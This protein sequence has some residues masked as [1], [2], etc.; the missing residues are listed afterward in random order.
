MP[1]LRT[2][3]AAVALVLLAGAGCSQ[4]E[5][6]QFARDGTSTTTS[7]APSVTVTP[8][9]SDVPATS[10]PEVTTT[11]IGNPT[12][13]ART[14]TTVGGPGLPPLPPPTQPVITGA[15]TDE[16]A[17]NLRSEPGCEGG[18]AVVRLFWRPVGAAEQQVAV[19]ARP[20]GLDGGNYTTSET[21]PAARG[22]YVLRESQP[23]G[24]YYWRVLTRRGSGWAASET[25]QFEGP[26]CTSF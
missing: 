16:T 7:P 5:F 26:V 2:R 15:R 14:Q 8:T 20:D 22:D 12:T 21:L 13:T 11:T 4:G 23:G 17:T 25:A 10:A 3:S 9:A 6:G 24:I 1:T 19:S 18:R